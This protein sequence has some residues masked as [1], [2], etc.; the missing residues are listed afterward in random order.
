M[1]TAIRDLATDDTMKTRAVRL[2]RAII[3]LAIG[4][5]FA[6]AITSVIVFSLGAEVP[7]EGRSDPYVLT[8]QGTSV[9]VPPIVYHLFQ[10]QQI[11][12]VVLFVPLLGAIAYSVWVK[13][14]SGGRK[15]STRGKG[16]G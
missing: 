11:V 14:I 9:Q 1:V 2:A 13:H 8:Q 12:A 15:W 7:S 5:F 10:V 3:Y 16:T 4:N 6:L